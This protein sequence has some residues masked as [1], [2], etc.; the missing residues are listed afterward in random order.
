MRPSVSTL[1]AVVRA[2][3][4]R[5]AGWAAGGALVFGMVVGP[6]ASRTA[7]LPAMPADGVR[8][9]ATVS[10]V[11]D[12]IVAVDL[13]AAARLTELGDRSV[14]QHA[15]ADAEAAFRGA[16]ALVEGASGSANPRLADS[17]TALAD[18]RSERHDFS[19][20]ETL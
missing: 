12:A 19:G 17:L 20:A 10:A 11:N 16:L 8:G 4:L 9:A 2:W 5:G 7:A 3:A 6:G 13:D 18:V 15:L 1:A 14:E